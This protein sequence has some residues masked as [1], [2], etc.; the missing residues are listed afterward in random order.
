MIKLL[1]GKAGSGKSHIGKLSSL[2]YGYHFHDADDDLPEVFR[3]AIANRESVSD[4]VREEFI[5]TIIAT[6][7][8]LVLAH[9]DICMCQALP[10][11]K[12]REK[13]LKAIPSV[14]YVWVDA[15]DDLILSR[16]ENRA[17]HIAQRSYAEMANRI[18]EIPT[19]AHVRFENGDDPIKFDDQMKAIFGRNSKSGV[20]LAGRKTE[21]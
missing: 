11:N 4:E 9:K 8:R 12:Y 14:E 17:G 15:P 20:A 6:I 21:T 3:K 5:E 18:F 7:R 2:A 16:L 13:I 19:V 10:R 1:F